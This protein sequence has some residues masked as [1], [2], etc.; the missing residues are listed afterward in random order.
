MTIQDVIKYFRKKI[1]DGENPGSQTDSAYRLY[2]NAIL[3]VKAG[4]LEEARQNLKDAVKKAPDFDDAY[5]LLGLTLLALSNRIESIKAINQ[6]QDG[7]KHNQAMRLY[8]M[9]CR[10]AGDESAEGTFRGA[11][12]ETEEERKARQAERMRRDAPENANGGATSDVE[13]RTGTGGVTDVVFDVDGESE[14]QRDGSRGSDIA[15]NDFRR[16]FEL[17]Q[18]TAERNR[19]AVEN[20]RPGADV[21]KRPSKPVVPH[22]QTGNRVT[23]S[24]NAEAPERDEETEDTVRNIPSPDSRPGENT[25]SGD[26]PAVDPQDKPEGAGAGSEGQSGEDVPNG[27]VKKTGG[28]NAKGRKT[29]LL[30]L[31]IL[32]CVAFV[33]AVSILA[34]KLHSKYVKEHGLESTATPTASAAGATPG[35]QETES[36]VP[37]PTAGAETPTEEPTEVPTETPYVTETPTEEPTEKPPTDAE[38]AAMQAKKLADLKA[39]Y[40]AGEYYECYKQIVETSWTHLDKTGTAEKDDLAAKALDAFSRKYFNLMYKAV[41]EENWPVVLGYAEA[42]IQYNPDYEKG[43]PV[44]FHAGKAAELT[45]DKEKAKYY[46]N[47]TMTKYPASSDAGYAKYR[48]SQIKP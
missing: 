38:L 47:L 34:V 13:K 2:N 44:Y 17:A 5:A 6:I 26:F 32:I 15:K 30:F 7:A 1:V 20:G 8:D 33:A 12:N 3:L 43:A 35:S 48:L 28:E 41:G 18:R 19:N 9:L 27:V 42:I 24:S 11:G 45:G 39:L 46:Y 29:V 22:P 25:P 21:T 36:P 4:R 37:T 10:D 16:R 40:S 14:S 23:G 31:V